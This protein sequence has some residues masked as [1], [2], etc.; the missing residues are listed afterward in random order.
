MRSPAELTTRFRQQ[1][2]RVTPQR[3]CIFRLLEGNEEHPTAEWLYERAREQMPTISLKTVY[4]T[5]HDL[6]VMGEI[7]ELDVGTGAH[8]FE[9]NVDGHHHLV[10][11]RCG[12]TRDVHVDVSRLRPPRSE[13][14]HFTMGTTEVVFRGLC[15]Q[16]SESPRRQPAARR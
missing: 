4:Q 11:R 15:E 5:L 12:R 13:S 14:R 16:C 1:G 6:A 3:Q 8:R 10:C 9:P 2:L 7:R